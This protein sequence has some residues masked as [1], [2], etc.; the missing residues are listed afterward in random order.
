[1]ERNNVSFLKPR[2]IGLIIKASGLLPSTVAFVALFLVC[3]VLVALFEPNVNGFANSLW[4]MFQV[5]S[6]IGLGDFTAT[7][8]VGRAAAVVLSVYSVFFL[9]LI[10][11]VVVSFC[12][13]RMRARRGES[14]AHFLDQL[15][16]L[17]ELSTEE[18]AELSEKVKR[19]KGNA[20]R[21]SE[22][23]TLH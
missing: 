19:F 2:A 16:H 9:A 22:P 21:D 15:E 23:I 8:F 1:M 17:P 3:S 6:T 5:V 4:F 10:T 18:L 12:S 7:S 20:K 11:G 13:E 14:I